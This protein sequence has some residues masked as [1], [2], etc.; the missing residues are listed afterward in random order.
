MFWKISW[1]GSKFSFPHVCWEQAGRKLFIFHNQGKQTSGTWN[2]K[3]RQQHCQTTID[4]N[5][6]TQN[7]QI[8]LKDRMQGYLYISCQT[9]KYT[10]QQQ[11][12]GYNETVTPEFMN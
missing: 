4:T 12:S 2:W 10:M 6:T 1:W 11:K 7:K 9:K 3:R 8:T 5:Y